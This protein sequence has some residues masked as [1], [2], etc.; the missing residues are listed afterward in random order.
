[1]SR[2][3][4][5]NVKNQ[6]RKY[7]SILSTLHLLKQIT[8]LSSNL[9]SKTAS[10]FTGGGGGPACQG[11]HRATSGS[12]RATSGSHRA[13]SGRGTTIRRAGAWAAA[14]STSLAPPPPWRPDAQPGPPGP[15]CSPCTVC[16]GSSSRWHFPSRST[17]TCT[18][19]ALCGLESD[20][21]AAE[22]HTVSAERPHRPPGVTGCLRLTRWRRWD[23]TAEGE[24]WP[25][26]SGA[27]P[28][29]TQQT[30]SSIKMLSSKKYNW[31]LSVKSTS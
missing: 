13:T 21:L 31:I 9:S 5:N 25:S 22:T 15:G 16:R 30:P 3:Q 6:K 18:P 4:K 10:G 23:F 26:T 8:A 1:M 7:E 27:V 24:S 17:P 19:P 14:C 28:K 12:H 2:F 20:F 29:R 11:S